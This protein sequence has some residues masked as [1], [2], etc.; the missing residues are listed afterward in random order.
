MPTFEFWYSETYDFKGWFT[1]ETQEQADEL[2]NQ[3]E[4]GEIEIGYLPNFASK[5]KG[6]TCETGIATQIENAS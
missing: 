5:D 6:Y 3:L 4:L 1:A 2:L